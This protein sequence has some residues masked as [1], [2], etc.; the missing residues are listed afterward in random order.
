MFAR[1]W[2]AG[3]GAFLLPGTFLAWP[4]VVVELK[5]G[6]ALPWVRGRFAVD[7]YAGA[8]VG[9]EC[10]FVVH[11]CGEAR[12]ERAPSGGDAAG[13]LAVDAFRGFDRGQGVARA[14]GLVTVLV[15]EEQRYEGLSHVP[16]DVAGEHAQEQ[17][18]PHPLLQSVL[19]GLHPQVHA[20]ERAERTHALLQPLVATRFVLRRE[21]W[22]GS[23]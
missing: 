12:E 14:M 21:R 18:H 2:S 19:D 13:L 22:L 6:A 3:R 5:E 7:G 16:F 23:R 8:F 20:I 17:V 1:G 9:P 4:E 11:D 10:T 15:I